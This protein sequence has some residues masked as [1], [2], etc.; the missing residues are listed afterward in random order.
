MDTQQGRELPNQQTVIKSQ[1]SLFHSIPMSGAE[2]I[3]FRNTNSMLDSYD[4][5]NQSTHIN[6]QLYIDKLID[7]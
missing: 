4:M 5:E 6:T 1:S 2:V 7:Q 3:P